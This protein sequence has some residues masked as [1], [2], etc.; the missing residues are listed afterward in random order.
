MAF[1]TE[2]ERA[3]ARGLSDLFL[4]NPFL[5]DWVSAQRTVLGQEFVTA[6]PVWH[7]HP[8][9]LDRNPNIAALNARIEAFATR[10]RERLVDGADPGPDAELYQDLSSYLLFAHLEPEL[11]QLMAGPED[12]TTWP[13]FARFVRDVRHRLDFPALGPLPD[14]AHLLALFFQIRRAF[15]FTHEYISGRSAPAV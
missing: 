3:F 4:A 5:P 7:A 12:V 14:P 1:M 8:N 11:K 2:T 9:P 10:L 13:G 6:P 15:H